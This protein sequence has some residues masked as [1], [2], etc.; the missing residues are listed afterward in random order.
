[1]R[2]CASQ[3]T[4]VQPC[5]PVAPVQS[6]WG[7][8]P[9]VLFTCCQD[10]WACINLSSPVHS[11]VNDT[12]TPVRIPVPVAVSLSRK[13]IHDARLPQHCMY[14][15]PCK[16][17]IT[18]APGTKTRAQQPCV[19]AGCVFVVST[20]SNKVCMMMLGCLRALQSDRSC[21]AFPVCS[22]PLFGNHL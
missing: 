8:L 20:E 18:A 4:Q 5:W 10:V 16:A 14:V 22:P 7:Y 13:L 11:V 17:P 6:L 2:V 3:G 15:I 21:T 19:E 1:M 9:A 12:P